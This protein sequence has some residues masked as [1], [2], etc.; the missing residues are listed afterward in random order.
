M[1]TIAA[2]LTC[3]NRREQT[4]AAL[5]ALHSQQL[6]ADACI[7]VYLTDDGSTDGSTKA[8]LAEFP[9]VNVLAGSGQLFWNGG[10]RMAMH[11]A[12]RSSP[13]YFLW[14]NDDTTLDETAVSSLLEV[15]ARS[16]NEVIAVAATRDPATLAHTYGGVVRPR[17]FKPVTFALVPVS[18]SVQSCE[19]MNGNCVLIPIEV[20]RCLGP[21]NEKFRHAMGDLD[22]GLRARSAGFRISVAPGTLGVCK[23]NDEGS[24]WQRAEIGRW[25]RVKEMQ[26]P[27]GLPL[28]DWRAFTSAHAGALWP[29]YW[30]WP[31]A[32]AL[33]SPCGAR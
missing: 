4:L 29:I 32:K 33:L 3:F 15:T 26:H 25:Q 8:V 16:G 13:D 28:S 21:M 22:Y 23:R 1:T 10:M 30:L 11:A 31:Y 17:P 27:K 2:V 24:K 9:G 20:Y 5:R 14:L 19:S 6:P 7:S 12:E 18:E